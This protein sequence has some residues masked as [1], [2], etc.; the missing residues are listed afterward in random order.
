MAQTVLMMREETRLE[1]ISEQIVRYANADFSTP[2]VLTDNGDQLDAIVT[3]LNV[4]GEELESYIHKLKAGENEIKKTIKLLNQA[5]HLT[6]LGSWEWD[7]KENTIRWSD[8]LYRIYGV[9]KDEFKVTPDNYHAFIHP[10]DVDFVKTSIEK[11]RTEGK[12]L[13]FVH[14]L[15]RPDGTVRTIRSL[16]EVHA[17]SNGN[18][19]RLTGT[20]QD[21]TDQR[22]A[23]EKM[24]RL[25]TIVES[26]SDAI[27]SKT[28]EGY[29]TSWNKQAEKLFGYTEEEILG[30]HISIIF[31]ADRM[32]EEEEIL[33]KITKG[34]PLLNYETEHKRKD[35][36]HVPISATISPIKDPSGKITG[37]SKIARDITEKKQAEEKMRTY[38]K[39]LEQKNKET[40]QFAYIASHDLQEPLRTITNYIGLFRDDYKGKL[41][42]NA[43]TYI[44]FID[45]ASKRMEILIT[46]L[47]EYTRIESDKKIV[48][49]DCNLLLQ[50][51]LKDMEKTIA[52]S[53]AQIQVDQL[54]TIKAHATRIRSLFQNLLANAIKFRK[55][56]TVPIIKISAKEK[57][58]EWLFEIRDNGIGIEKIY[59]DKIFLL[60]QRLHNRNEYQ[61]TGLG[62]ANCKKIV[63][64]RGGKIWV[65]SEVGKGST[66]FFTIPKGTIL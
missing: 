33:K 52:E 57:K 34:E 11:A 7:L 66:F 48:D 65:E 27:I 59:Y 18:A 1:R 38:T 26:S 54:P 62:L 55:K 15:V 30:K 31:T 3:G 45:G 64:L 51:I 19:Y 46:D 58:K 13:N 12:S 63:E 4:L 40:E 49:V 28:I 8:E 56:D 39:V 44:N 22:K 24:M 20:A 32:N 2:G 61:G 23:E 60:F 5:Q 50:E 43:D 6:H 9:T 53:K 25:A 47:L 17:D 29:I 21:I 42:K 41:D 16:G 36:R 37:I 35:G 14:R 10:D